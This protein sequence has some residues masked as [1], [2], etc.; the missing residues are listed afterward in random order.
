[1]NSSAAHAIWKM[2]T[3][4]ADVPVYD[5]EGSEYVHLQMFPKNQ[6]PTSELPVLLTNASSNQWEYQKADIDTTTFPPH[7]LRRYKCNFGETDF[8][9]AG[10]AHQM[11][12][13]DGA[14]I[15]VPPA[16]VN[17]GDGET[18]E[19][20]TEKKKKELAQKIQKHMEK[21]QELAITH[22]VIPLEKP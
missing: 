18:I 21:A 10:T 6:S 2:R 22:E 5:L 20:A 13:G 9:I 16:Q 1:M 17:V 14:A 8:F 12:T 3:Q 15:E 11:W 19:S 7:K 4:L